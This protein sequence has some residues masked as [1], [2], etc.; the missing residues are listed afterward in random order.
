[1]RT[2]LAINLAIAALPAVL[3]VGWSTNRTRISYREH[4]VAFLAGL[5]AIIPAFP[6]MLLLS[7]AFSGVGGAG[8]ELLQAFVVAG[9][10]EETAKLAPVSWVLQRHRVAER[11]ITGSGGGKRRRPPRKRSP[12]PISLA[13]TAGLGFAFLENGFYLA[14]SSSLLLMRAILAVPLHGATAAFLGIALAEAHQTAEKPGLPALGLAGA[15][16]VHGLYD[17]AARHVPALAPVVVAAAIVPAV[18]LANRARP[19]P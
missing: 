7:G 1:M 9:L 11:D 4:Y 5:L 17:L 6:A 12:A 10:V 18:M 13:V 3:F 19:T 8:A 16:L 14:G 15:T 2:G